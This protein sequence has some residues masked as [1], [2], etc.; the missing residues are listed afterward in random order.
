ML[1]YEEGETPGYCHDQPGHMYPSLELAHN[2]LCEMA[3]ESPDG[4]GGFCVESP[5]DTPTVMTLRLTPRY[6]AL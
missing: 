2:S 1:P 5:A 4:R 3:S 6:S